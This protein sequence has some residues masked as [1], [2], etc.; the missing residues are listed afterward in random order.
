MREIR[1]ENNDQNSLKCDDKYLC[2]GLR[3]S[4]KQHMKDEGKSQV[5]P[6]LVCP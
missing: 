4:V 2:T 3:K 5:T 1:R 6:L